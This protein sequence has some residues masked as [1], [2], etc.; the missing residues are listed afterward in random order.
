MRYFDVISSNV[1]K[2]W[3][4]NLTNNG[5]Q[6][7]VEDWIRHQDFM[8]IYIDGFEPNPELYGLLSSF[9]EIK[10]LIDKENIEIDD[11]V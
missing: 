11:M 9:Y 5:L 2:Y 10:E 7:I 1:S 6:I 3:H 4:L 8:R